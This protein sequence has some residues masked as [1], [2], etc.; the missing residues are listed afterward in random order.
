MYAEL[1]KRISDGQDLLAT[2]ILDVVPTLREESDVIDSLLK[3]TAQYSNAAVMDELTHI[4]GHTHKSLVDLLDTKGFCLRSTLLANAYIKGREKLVHALFDQKHSFF[5]S[6]TALVATVC[7]QLAY[8]SSLFRHL[9]DNEDRFDK[10]F[11]SRSK[12][13]LYEKALVYCCLNDQHNLARLLI[14]RKAT[15]SV[16]TLERFPSCLGRAM[17]EIGCVSTVKQV[18]RERKVKCVEVC[19]QNMQLFQLPQSWLSLLPDATKLDVSNN[20]LLSIPFGL[21]DGSMPLLLELDAS[22][23]K[24]ESIWHE[25]MNQ[26]STTKPK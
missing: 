15:V 9:L 23:N 16:D 22:N 26:L 8:P 4:L 25:D 21:L 20:Q 19:W 3:C 13:N 14:E 5:C 1:L 6:Y 10:P 2:D 24:L 7:L 11:C 18:T 12:E 17:K